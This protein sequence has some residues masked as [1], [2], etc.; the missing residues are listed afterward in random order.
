M[1]NRKKGFSML[2]K[3]LLVALLPIGIL[4][5]FAILSI[6]SVGNTVGENMARR[7][8]GATALALSMQLNLVSEGQYSYDGD[9]FIAGQSGY[10]EINQL[11]DGIKARTSVDCTVFVDDRRVV[12]TVKDVSGKRII[13][14][15]MSKEIYDFLNKEDTYFSQNTNVNGIQYIGLYEEIG[16]TKEGQR[17]IIFAGND[18]AS[19]N[20]IYSRFV[21][22]NGIFMVVLAMIAVV[23]IFF[24]V[25]S[26]TKAMGKAVSSL[27]SVAQGN[28]AESVD[29]KL[30][31]RSDEVG[32]IGQA[33]HT[34]ITNLAK[35]VESIS[36][37]S[38][39]M[40]ACASRFQ[41]SF[42]TIDES[43][44]N[45][46]VA[47]SEIATGA[48]SMADETQAVTEQMGNM[49]HA[50]ASTTENVDRLMTNADHMK[51]QN[52]RAGDIVEE[53]LAV[54]KATSEAVLCVQEQTNITNTSALKIQSA[55][56]LISDIAT[57]TN[58]LSLN[59]SIEAARAGEHGK[60]FAVVAEEV[61]KLADL[62]KESVLEIT[63]TITQ[64]IEESNISVKTM[65]AVIEDVKIQSSKMEETQKVFEQLNEDI[66]RVAESVNKIVREVASVEEGKNSVLV[67]MES[68]SAISQENAASTE[69]TTATMAEVSDIVAECNQ[70]VKNLVDLSKELTD[71]VK[72]FRVK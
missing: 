50:I 6:Q 44:N 10:E 25:R 26:M 38:H 63:T 33:V 31:Q 67:N 54:N 19:V 11:L 69:E 12:T 27:V 29:D 16:K 4:I 70:A 15:E 51:M 21:I 59:A 52:S 45:V 68:L 28:L 49:G 18:V 60:G 37:C 58:L 48:T 57:Q 34:L 5:V 14:T 32:D 7:E 35:I 71:N 40:D 62:S 61:R 8:L 42:T 55:I 22:A 1:S 53:L 72:K 2:K 3:L 30:L 47:I 20:S 43:V 17:V 56:D 41:E 24:I 36:G 23:C 64:L 9:A 65:N 13:G 66:M 46:N 39:A